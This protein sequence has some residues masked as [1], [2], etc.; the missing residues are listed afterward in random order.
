MLEDG[1][2]DL[3]A[4]TQPPFHESENTIPLLEGQGAPAESA[5][6]FNIEGIWSIDLPVGGSTIINWFL[7]LWTMLPMQAT[8]LVALKGATPL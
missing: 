5:V 8:L 4:T 6:I 7:N 3:L 2:I 1:L